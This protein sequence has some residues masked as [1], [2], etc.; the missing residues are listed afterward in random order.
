MVVPTS[1]SAMMMD[2]INDLVTDLGDVGFPFVSAMVLSETGMVAG[3]MRIEDGFGAGFVLVPADLDGTSVVRGHRW[4][5]RAALAEADVR[6]PHLREALLAAPDTAPRFDF[7][8][9]E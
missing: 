5:D 9:E 8:P 2:G 3:G 6:P 7:W 4:L 1:G